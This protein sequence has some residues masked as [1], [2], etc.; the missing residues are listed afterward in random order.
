MS[1]AS[2]ARTTKHRRNPFL[3]TA[4]EPTPTRS[5]TRTVGVPR[6]LAAYARPIRVRWGVEPARGVRCRCPCSS[7]PQVLQI[8]VDHLSQ[9][10]TES[11]IWIA[12]GLVLLLG[13]AH[14]S[15]MLEALADCGPDLT[16]ELSMRMNFFD[17]LLSAPAFSAGS[18]ASRSVA[19]PLHERF[20]DD[21]PLVVFRYCSRC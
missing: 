17:R 3:E 2:T 21:S 6:T 20:G 13:I 7:I 19:D 5:T 18:L 10:T 12:G 11:A 1:E 16:I 8:I 4:S 9:S 14:A 15:F